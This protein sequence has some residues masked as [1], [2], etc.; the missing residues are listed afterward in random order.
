[1][2]RFLVLA[3]AAAA[4]TTSACVTVIDGDHDDF[5]WHGEN[6]QPFDGSRDACRARA[7]RDQRSEAFRACMAEKGWTPSY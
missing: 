3:A 6:A 4:M 1:M 5:G 2:K 7:G